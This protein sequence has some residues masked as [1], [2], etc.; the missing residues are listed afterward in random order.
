MIPFS[1]FQHMTFL[2]HRVFKQMFAADSSKEGKAI[3]LLMNL[4]CE[5]N[6]LVQ[7]LQIQTSEN[8]KLIQ[9]ELQQRALIDGH[10]LGFVREGDKLIP[11]SFILS[12]LASA[13]FRACVKPKVMKI[14]WFFLFDDQLLDLMDTM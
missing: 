14:S 10:I 3:V 2:S 9:R 7:Q 1:P 5:L 4:G 11:K 6:S 12:K 8:A 13:F